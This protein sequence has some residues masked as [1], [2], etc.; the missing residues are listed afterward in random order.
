MRVRVVG[1]VIAG[2]LIF[3]L[4]AAS[5][6]AQAPPSSSVAMPRANDDRLAKIIQTISADKVAEI[7]KK[8]VSFGTRAST[9]ETTST[10]TR[11]VVPARQ[12]IYEQFQAISKANGGR[13]KVSID[14][15]PVPK[16]SRIPV[17][18][19]MS[20]VVAIL[21]GT[22]PNDSRVVVV[23][24]H[25]D[26]I[27]GGD[28]DGPGANDDGSGTV[29][30]LECARA[31][32]QFQFPATIMF[33]AVEG[34]EQGLYGSKHAAESAKAANMNIVAMLNNDIVGGDQ[35]PGRENKDLV[36]VFSLGVP[37]KSTPEELARIAS[38]GLENDSPSRQVARYAS[39]IADAYLPGFKVVMQYRTD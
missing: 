34:E 16:G 32:A 23:S 31:L 22:D 38:N 27:P 21:P 20:N 2:V 9:T 11:G 7:D 6:F 28:Q 24:G 10:A 13:L 17:D 36:R 3:G 12:W 26:S 29:V 4:G 18:Q 8:L 14:T 5:D 19:T 25:Y 35:T 33:L 15:F 30:S 39:A 1:S 37:P